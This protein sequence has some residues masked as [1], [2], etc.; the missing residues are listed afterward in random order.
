MADTQV[1]TGNGTLNDA[2]ANE[3]AT[4]AYEIE[5]LIADNSEWGGSL[6]FPNEETTVEPG[7]Y[8]LTLEDGVQVDIDL[9]PAVDSD[10]RDHAFKGIG[11]FGQRVLE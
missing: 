9:A 3:L 4:V 11:V 1:L 10:G 8:V 2:D 6:S 7:M 5:P